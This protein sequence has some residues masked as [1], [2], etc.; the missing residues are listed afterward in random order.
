MHNAEGEQTWERKLDT[1]GKVITGDNNSCPFMYQGQYYDPEIEL[2]YNRF[3]YYDP[4]D[5][6]YISVDP[7]GLN[8]GEFN[9]YNYVG[10]P[11]G[12]I[13][14]LGLKSYHGNDKRN[15]KAQHGYEIYNKDGK[16]VKTGV[17]SGK[18][19]G[20]Q[21]KRADKQV[22]NLNNKPTEFKNGPY[23]SKIVEHQKGGKNARGKIYEWEQ[24]NTNKHSGTL[25]RNIHK[26]P[27][28]EID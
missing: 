28:P 23:T 19:D 15:T 20:N 9:F 10:D 1:F 12:W 14:A 13:D 16:V 25:D 2:A 3:R 24:G 7:I 27:S 18:F 22:K 4:E 17:S 26:R 6:R 21:S 8:S 11:N 5:G